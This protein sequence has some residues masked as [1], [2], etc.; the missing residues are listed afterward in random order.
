MIE[1]L[2]LYVW[3]ITIPSS[4][5]KDKGTPKNNTYPLLKTVS[6]RVL[7]IFICIFKRNLNSYIA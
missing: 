2:T 4:G 5:V 6:V 7:D 3:N 1:I